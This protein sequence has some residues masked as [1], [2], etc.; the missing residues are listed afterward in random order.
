MV[1]SVY[2]RHHYFSMQCQIL[3]RQLIKRTNIAWE[4]LGDDRAETFKKKSFKEDKAASPER[5]Q[6]ER[7]NL[8]YIIYEHFG[9]NTLELVEDDEKNKSST[10]M[11]LETGYPV[12]KYIEDKETYF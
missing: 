1:N 8:G 10:N 6:R 12:D 2:I 4:N 5:G 7:K 9:K 11:E 3:E